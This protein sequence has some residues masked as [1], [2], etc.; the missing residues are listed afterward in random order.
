M[1]QRGRPFKWTAEHTANARSYYK[2]GYS[3]KAIAMKMGFHYSTI[4]QK[5]NAAGVQMRPNMVE[6]TEG[7]SARN[8]SI[9]AMYNQGVSLTSIGRKHGISR[10]RVFQIVSNFPRRDAID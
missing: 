4:R 7:L 5:L 2:E 8:R 10:Q 1:K 9:W 6:A 3:L